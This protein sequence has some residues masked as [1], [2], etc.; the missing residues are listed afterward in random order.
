MHDLYVFN[1]FLYTSCMHTPSKTIFN[2]QNATPELTPLV[3]DGAT[4]LF[5]Q[6]KRALLK[7]IEQ[8]RYRPGQTL[9]NEAGI[10][11]ALGVS[12]GTLRKAVDELVHEHILVRRQGKGTFVALHNSDR[13]LFQF[14]HVQR[15]PGPDA[16][17][18]AAMHERE[19]P[20]VDTVRFELAKCNDEEAHMLRLRPGA[21]VLRIDNRLSLGNSAVVHDRISL[22]EQ[23]YKGLDRARLEARPSTLYNLYQTDYGITVLR[24]QERARA[25]ACNAEV[26]RV[27]GL[28]TGQPV[29]EVHRLALS[30]GEKPVE[31]RVSSIDTTAHDYVNT[32]SKPR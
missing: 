6:V 8:G 2:S 10:S 30:F 26:A 1:N 18:D 15:R 13:F 31:Y 23:M 11:A 4:P 28:R 14:F 19:M 7:L 29:I 24:A 32:L 20:V 16:M 9:P 17:A 25:A 21:A 5:R 27:L 22:P 3:D 12:I